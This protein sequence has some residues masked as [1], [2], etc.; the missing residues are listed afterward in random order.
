MTNEKEPTR[1]VEGAR[2]QD[3]R[4]GTVW[5]RIEKGAQPMAFVPMPTSGPTGN[6]P[7]SDSTPNPAAAVEQ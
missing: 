3:E 6:A 1:L 5:G 7:A 2:I 4:G